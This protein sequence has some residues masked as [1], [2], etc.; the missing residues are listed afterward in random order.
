M[1]ISGAEAILRSLVAEKVDTIFGYPGGA[2]MPIYDALF[3]YSKKLRHVLVRHEQGAA[4]AA[5]GYARVTG[6]PGVCLVTS[7]PGATNL[8]TGI[9]DAMMDSVPL[10]C[11]TGQ[12]AAH[13]LGSDAFQEADVIGITTPIT[14]WNYQVTRAE[15]IP[16]I[17]AKAFMIARHG[18]PGSVVVDI[19]K[20]AQIEMLDFEYP[21]NITVQ[22]FVEDLP[23]NPGAIK[24]AA[25]W[26]NEAKRPYVLIGHGV[27]ISQAESEVQKIM[28]KAEIPGAVTLH[29]LSSIPCDH[30]FYVGMLG[31]HG[32]LGPN[33]LT[34]KADVILAVGIRFDDR[35]TG[36]LSHYAPQAKIIHIDIDASELHK[37]VTA[38]IAIQADAKTALKALLP[39]IKKQKHD[40]W[41][42]AFSEQKKQE[43]TAAHTRTNKR[44]KDTINMQDVIETLS[45]ETDGQAIVV[46]DVGQNQMFS[47]RYYQY[48]N[49]NSYITSGGLGTMGFSLPAAIGA[50]IAA[51]KKEVYSISGDGGIQMN[52]QELATVSQ[53]KI[54]LKI[55]VL[56]NGFL[57]MV[58]QWQ[59]LFFKKRYSSTPIT[60]PNIVQLAKAYDIEANSIQYHS[61]LLSAI[62]KMRGYEGAYILEVKVEAE[63]NIF[64]MIPSGA[65]VE[66]VKLSE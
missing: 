11:I 26:I 13:L 3:D 51:P 14:K 33:V 18:R 57:G 64:P 39:L 9:A 25:Q 44:K 61:E 36:R 37:N 42:S 38:H 58:R 41:F 50:Q 19:A 5:E 55:I 53:E 23:L 24:L 27:L 60:G 65:S 12:V 59:Q 30:P 45:K 20:N 34:N 35:V 17:L 4:H 29:G 7:G 62:K 28:E 40:V 54:P 63:D 56:N 46:A 32:N 8:V 22:K 49:P 48:K 31:M 43:E 66:E 1:K 15:E 6:Q 21:K 16:F 10:V 2:N 47:A 52:I